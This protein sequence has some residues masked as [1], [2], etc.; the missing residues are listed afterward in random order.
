MQR[1]LRYGKYEEEDLS[2]TPVEMPIGYMRPT[3]L[4]DLIAKM[5]RA[6][7]INEEKEEFETEEESDDFEEEN[8]ELLDMSPYTLTNL[9][10]EE[11]ISQEDPDPP[12]VLQPTP[13]LSPT[14]DPPDP[15]A[16]EPDTP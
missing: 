2:T 3:P 9:Q 11:P 14:G 4:Q 7:V 5:V 10:E 13:D 8:P 16:E 15:E 12:D 1:P 6:A